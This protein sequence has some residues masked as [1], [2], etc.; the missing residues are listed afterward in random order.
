MKTSEASATTSLRKEWFS[1]AAMQTNGFWQS[2]Q[3]RSATN[4]TC[5]NDSAVS[6]G[7]AQGCECNYLS[8]TWPGVNV[9][10]NTL[11][12]NDDWPF[13]PIAYVE[14]RTRYSLGVS[15]C[16]RVAS[17]RFVNQGRGRC[18]SAGPAERK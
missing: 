14:Y 16:V 6:T 8:C 17:L 18:P 7:V 11:G 4:L 12:N 1:T 2:I 9:D 3:N 13:L 10:G 15:N 5:G